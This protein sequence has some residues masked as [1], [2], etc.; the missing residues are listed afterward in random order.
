MVEVLDLKY[1]PVGVNLMSVERDIPGTE[2]LNKH[3]YCQ[4]LMLAR[5]GKGVLLRANGLSCPAA[6]SCFGYQEL[7]ENL[8]T[9][10]SLVDFGIVSEEA[11]GQRMFAEMPRLQPG[12][13]KQ[14]HLFPLERSNCVPNIVVVEDE[15]EKL[16]W[17]LLAYLNLKVGQRV[18]SNTAVLQAACVDATVVPYL[19]D[20]LNFSFGCY[21]CRDATDIGA[22]EAI[23]GFPGRFLSS[24]VDNLV[25]L[26][27]KAIP[28]SRSKQALSALKTINP[29]DQ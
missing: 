11:A 26:S 10:R 17:I 24:I 2:L 13:I 20:R 23:L 5:K 7:T 27:K 4:G 28:T 14:L 1:S 19:E 29:A 3:R 8:K 9:G 18:Y 16:M 15:V 22:G 12:S 25:N 6:S 21:G